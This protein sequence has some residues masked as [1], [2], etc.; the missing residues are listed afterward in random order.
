VNAAIAKAKPDDEKVKAL[1]DS[2]SEQR[3]NAL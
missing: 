2:I 3:K 1:V